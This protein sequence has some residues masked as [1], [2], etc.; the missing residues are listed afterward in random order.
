MTH[1]CCSQHLETLVAQDMSA[2]AKFFFFTGFFLTDSL[3][4]SLKIARHAV[5]ESKLL[6][7]N[8]AAPFVI[9]ARWYAHVCRARVES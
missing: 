7:F 5:D 1:A 3:E 2:R 8:I 4:S 9:E 6:L